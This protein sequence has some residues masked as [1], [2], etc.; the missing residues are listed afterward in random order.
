M[1]WM[2]A[3]GMAPAHAG[4]QAAPWQEAGAPLQVDSDTL[5]LRGAEGVVLFV[6]HVVARQGDLTVQ[7]DRAE[8]TFDRQTRAL[9]SVDATGNVRVEKGEVV[10]TGDR[11][12]YDAAAGVVTLTGS[13]KVWRGRDVVAG[14]RITLYLAED[15]SVVEG[16]RAV[17]FP[18]GSQQQEQR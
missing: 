3:G 14:D 10:A 18:G 6:G 16:A 9:L 8:V 4:P 17:L 13:P 2:W 12:R 1:L 11:G 5:E 15:R 7:A